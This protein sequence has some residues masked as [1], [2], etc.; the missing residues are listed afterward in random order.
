M[1]TLDGIQQGT[2]QWLAIRRQYLCASEA[3]A[4]LGFDKRVSRTD[5][6]RM[7]A[8][9]S[10]REFSNWTQKNLLDR[11]HEIEAVAR[12]V[13]ERI[14]GDDLYPV[15]GVLELDGLPLLASFDGVVMD[16]SIVW[17]CKSRN[18]ALITALEAGVLPDEN[19]PQ[20]EQQL[21]I[22][23]ASK[24]L[25]TPTDG[26]EEGTVKF[27]YASHPDRRSALI[28]GWRQFQTDRGSYEHVE[29]MPLPVVAPIEDLPAL[30]V[31]L[32]GEVKS[33]N[34]VIFKSTVLARIQAINTDLKTDDDF[35][36][37]DKMVKF[38]DDGEKCLD[39]VKSQALS[40]TASIDELFRTI[41]GLKGE[42]RAKRLTLTN[43][44]KAR[45][46][47]IRFEI[48]QGGKFALDEHIVSLN[49]RLGK[50]YMPVIPA[51]FAGVIKGKKTITSLRDAVDTE[52]ARA[53]IEANRIADL[54]QINLNCL[55]DTAKDH[56][57]LFSD[58]AQLVLKDAEYVEAIIKSRIADHTA[59]EAKR[60]EAER[61][62]IRAEEQAKLI[63]EQQRQ[64]RLAQ[65]GRDEAE[66]VRQQII[67]EQE[68][69]AAQV[70]E[71]ARA[72]ALLHATAPAFA[73]PLKAI[74]KAIPSDTEIIHA[75][76]VAFRVDDSTAL[77][78]IIAMFERR[79]A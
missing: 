36:A 57:F 3:A 50:S 49:K 28:S 37:A 12:S 23:G 27:W 40:Q 72:G 71:P 47:Q 7:K 5:L 43:L 18:A 70:S 19:W 20:V 75:V 45:K 39:L 22:S 26:T 31:E 14:V 51:D 78:W 69:A 52:L 1:K 65:Q 60:I 67:R 44:V 61:E 42:M 41:D 53:K 10:E 25:L 38:L 55:R 64:E 59:A 13:A 6:L 54:I 73:A 30:T 9:G 68:S 24:A 11:G 29:A 34:L 33:S 8:T 32:V 58:A 74:P 17:E 46:E 62:R 66:R 79:V 15:V 63:A 4:M 16:E 77:D 35:A 21:L 76:A 56:V 48:V 2:D